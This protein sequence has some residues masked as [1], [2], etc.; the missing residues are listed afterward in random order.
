MVNDIKHEGG[1]DTTAGKPSD[2]R[3]LALRGV[4]GSCFT[5][6]ITAKAQGGVVA[7]PIRAGA[8]QC[9]GVRGRLYIYITQHVS[10]MWTMRHLYEYRHLLDQLC[11]LMC[12]IVGKLCLLACQGMPVFMLLTHGVLCCDHLPKNGLTHGFVLAM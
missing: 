6:Q 10:A 7:L 3:L 1:Q 12:Q 2:G 9:A 8:R 11:L 4:D 5:G